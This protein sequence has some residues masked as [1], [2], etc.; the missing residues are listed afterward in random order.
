MPTPASCVIPFASWD[1]LLNTLQ[2]E[3][4]GVKGIRVVL[5]TDASPTRSAN[6]VLSKPAIQVAQEC[7]TLDSEN[8][9]ALVL[10]ADT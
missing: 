1:E 2:V 3:S 6:C 4:G 8:Q 9:P 5:I 7:I 10:I